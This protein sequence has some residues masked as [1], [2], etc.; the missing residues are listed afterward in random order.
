MFNKYWSSLRFDF[1]NS[2]ISYMYYPEHFQS[3]PK[4]FCRWHTTPNL[5][6]TSDLVTFTVEILNGKLHFFCSDTL[7]FS[8]CENPSI[9]SEQRCNNLRK[10]EDI[11]GENGPQSWFFQASHR[12]HHLPIYFN[13]TLVIEDEQL[14]HLW[15][16]K[17]LS[18]KKAVGL[19]CKQKK[20]L[21]RSS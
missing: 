21:S 2:F 7:F 15:I 6:F 10:M 20:F 18:F 8:V 19:L 5:Q 16:N 17:F 13:N 1:R 4:R 14:K 12:G 11:S 9:T 3:M